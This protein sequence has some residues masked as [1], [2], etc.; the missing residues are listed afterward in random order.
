MSGAGRKGGYRKS[1]TDAYEIGLPE[2]SINELVG[3]IKSCLG[4]N[5]FDVE[6]PSPKQS[7]SVVLPSKFR[8]VIWVKRGDYVIVDIGNNDIKTTAN[9]DN[10]KPGQG[11]GNDDD[12]MP[13]YHNNEDD[14]YDDEMVD[15]NGNI[16]ENE[17][18]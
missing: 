2:P 8:K 9:N 1:V 15:D 14:D 10:N 4:G 7:C 13:G 5:M 11:Y 17:N 18:I 3:R 12:T 6:F 16:D